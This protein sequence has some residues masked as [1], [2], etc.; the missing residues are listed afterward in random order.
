MLSWIRSLGVSGCLVLALG[1]CGDG[2]NDDDDGGNG[3]GGGG[4]GA[5]T[6][7][8]DGVDWAASDNTISAQVVAAVPGAYT[9][10][11]TDVLSGSDVAGI[12]LTLYNVRGL[13]TYPLGTFPTVVGGIATYAEAIG[14]SSVAWVTQ[15]TGA[16]GTVTLTALTPTRIAGTFSYTAE[17]PGTGGV[18]EIT[19]GQF[20]LPLTSS[21]TLPTLPDNAG[22]RLTGTFGGTAY[23]AAMVAVT[24]SGASGF[25]VTSF[26]GTYSA[27][28][29]LDGITAAG[30]Y[31]VSLASPTRIIAVNAT[32]GASP[33]P[34]WGTGAGTSGSVTITSISA[35]RVQGTYTGTLQPTA[36]TPGAGALSV[37]GTFD[38]G[39][40]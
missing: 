16:A 38:V 13:G 6:A 1:A 9:I 3:G 8:V 26:N 35:T 25:S 31:P 34:S 33:R 12:T 10:V 7:E 23:N 24:Q 17:D 2:G 14:G 18:R 37:S 27:S 22:S 28:I 40:P 19:N 15:Y 21:G 36:S 5:F 4:T 39:L 11:G 20:D 30:T 32:T 29:L